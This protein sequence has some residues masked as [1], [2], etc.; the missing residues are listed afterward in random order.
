[1]SVLQ[2]DCTAC[3][4]TDISTCSQNN[5]AE[6]QTFTDGNELL[7]KWGRQGGV[8]FVRVII[9]IVIITM[10][11]P[12]CVLLMIT[13]VYRSVFAQWSVRLSLWSQSPLN[14]LLLPP[15]RIAPP[16][17]PPLIA[18][19]VSCYNQASLS[20]L[21]FIKNSSKNEH[22]ATPVLASPTRPP[23]TPPPPKY[24]CCTWRGYDHRKI[25]WDSINW[26]SRNKK[27]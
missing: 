22:L 16:P 20:P 26:T 3:A 10:S 27:L 25:T 13:T 1:M 15:P 9:I 8:S 24:D 12:R 19:T 6:C 7:M 21:Q 18:W 17:A 4:H 14:W 23:P 11:G 2:S 5:L